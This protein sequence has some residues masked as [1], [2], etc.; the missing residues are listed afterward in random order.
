MKTFASSRAAEVRSGERVRDVRGDVSEHIWTR[1]PRNAGQTPS[2]GRPRGGL[3][4]SAGVS[5]QTKK[6]EKG[7]V[8][9]VR[10]V[11]TTAVAFNPPRPPGLLCVG[12]SLT[13]LPKILQNSKCVFTSHPADVIRAVTCGAL[14][15][16]SRGKKKKKNH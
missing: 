10:V 5:G 4:V 8:Q 16:K 14:I 15:R 6:K 9:R 7:I 11:S 2:S 1:E 12:K 3:C 13:A